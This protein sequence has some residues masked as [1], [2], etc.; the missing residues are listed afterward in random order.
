MNP[1]ITPLISIF[2]ICALL[3]DLMPPN[4]GPLSPC[5]LFPAPLSVLR[6]YRLR[7]LLFQL[8][9]SSPSCSFHLRLLRLSCTPRSAMQLV[10]TDGEPGQL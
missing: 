4:L 1:S 9:L 8:V 10:N 3:F 7:S 2:A 6:S 5:L